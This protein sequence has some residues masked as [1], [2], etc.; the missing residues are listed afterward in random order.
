MKYERNLMVAMRDGVRLAT[1]VYFPDG[2][3]PWPVLLERTPYDKLGT[4]LVKAAGFF[5]RHGYAVALQDVRGREASEGDWYPFR[6]EA[7]DGYDAC[8]WLAA[9]PWC[10]G[11]IGTIGLSYSGCTQVGLGALAAPGLAAQWISMGPQNYRDAAMR[12]GGALELRFL[13]YAFRMAATSKEARTDPVARIALQRAHENVGKWLLPPGRVPPKPGVSPLKFTPGIE[14]WAH[15]I[16]REGDYRPYWAD[17][18]A[19]SVIPHYDRYPDVPITYLSGWYDTY[20]RGTL[21]NFGEMRRR[22]AAPTRL[23]MGP[24]THGVTTLGVSY[25]GDIEFGPDAALHYDDARLRW[26]DATLRGRDAGW[27]QGEPPVSI[28]VMGGGSGRRTPTGRMLHGGRW[29]Q[30]PTWPPAAV[31]PRSL[32]LRAGG[33]LT[34][35]APTGG[36]PADRYLYDPADPVPTVGGSISAAEN[37]IPA[38][39]Y[40]Q[41]GG[42]GVFGSRDDLPLASRPDVLVY[43]TEPLPDDIEVTGAVEVV[44]WASSSAPDTDFT[45]KL[46]DAYPPNPD[47]PEGYELNIADSIVRARYRSDGETADPPLE[48]GRPYELRIRLYATSNVF[49]AGHRIRV[50]VS[51]S[52]YPRF[53]INP[54]TGAALGENQVMRTAIQTIFHDVDRPS[55]VVLPTV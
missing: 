29:R 54:N 50:H 52:N 28:F 46:I 5:A 19:L 51:S 21:G 43:S 35:Q 4:E 7:P 41:R 11:R 48:P 55:R 23:I 8:A 33:R 37:V 9:Q 45:A 36:E 22:H 27:L 17:A 40:D 31:T 25:A 44:L 42:P 18:P 30:L 10:D 12:Q 2:G 3:G 39:G 13:I 53:D 15:D 20:I 6:E 16:L 1:D 32:H 14:R 49:C 34:W 47:Y 24:W 26:F 38:G